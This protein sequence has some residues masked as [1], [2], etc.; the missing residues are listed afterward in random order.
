MCDRGGKGFVKT[1]FD[2]NFEVNIE[3]FCSLYI[4]HASLNM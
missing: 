4:V 1:V 3:P 2:I